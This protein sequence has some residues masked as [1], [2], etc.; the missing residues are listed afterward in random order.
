MFMLPIFCRSLSDYKVVFI[1]LGLVH[2]L[3]WQVFWLFYC[4]SSL[5]ESFYRWSH[6]DMV[7]V[8]WI[9]GVERLRILMIYLR[10]HGHEGCPFELYLPV[11]KKISIAWPQQP[12]TEKVLN[13][14]LIF[15]ILPSK[16]I[17]MTTLLTHTV[18]HSTKPSFRP[19]ANNQPLKKFLS[20][21]LSWTK[22]V[23]NWTSF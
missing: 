16:T 18:A 5:V 13:F 2:K 15:M 20:L 10:L 23:K 12:L 19:K 21:A 22:G 14:N 1:T 17:S 7:K 3:H 4:L 9:W 6:S 8:K 11:F